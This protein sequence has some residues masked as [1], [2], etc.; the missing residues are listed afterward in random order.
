MAKMTNCKACGAEIS[1]SA[2][3]CPHCGHKNKRG[4]FKILLGLIIILFGLSILIGGIAALLGGDSSSSSSSG[5]NFIQ[6]ANNKNASTKLETVSEPEIVVGDF[7]TKSVNGSMKNISGE[8]LSYVQITFAL[9]DDDGA[10][11]GTAVANIN[12][13]TADSVW[14]YSAVPLTMDDFTSCKLTE[15][16]CW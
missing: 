8:T 2:K 13:L 6:A 15:I 7:G 12:N 10:Q 1:K 11:I 4:P 9:Y 16:D 3:T 5:E 14:K